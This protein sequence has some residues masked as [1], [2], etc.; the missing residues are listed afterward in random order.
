[1]NDW[2][3]LT[4]IYAILVS[5]SEVTKKKATK[6]NSIIEVLAGHILV[7]LIVTFF[8][9]KGIFE[10]NYNFLPIIFIKS[11]IIYVTWILGLKALDGLELG[12]YGMVKISR[13]IFSVLLSCIILGESI[14]L[15]TAIGMAMIITG[16]VLV[17]T[18]AIDDSNK[19]NSWKLILLFLVSCLGS[20]VSAIIDKK[21]LG[22]V[23][24][25]QLQFWFLLFLTFFYWITLF[26]KKEKIN[27]KNLKT[28]YWILIVGIMLAIGDRLLFIAN[29]NP[30]SK[31]IVMTMLKQL[32]VV[33]SIILGKL[34]FHE[35]NIL[36]KLLYSIL[37]IS[38]VVL[39][40]IF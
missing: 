9:T 10:I 3:L 24:S 17:N 1:M 37:I 40:S 34:I 26:A 21:I 2:I 16:L 30:D 29:Q 35:K 19:K 14:T 15:V 6:N 23:S 11:L 33:I 13:V 4:T 12:I 31:V 32:S 22:Y 36:K 38:G 25:G 7:A 20:S 28:N 39:I 18:T 5:L 8:T 27:F